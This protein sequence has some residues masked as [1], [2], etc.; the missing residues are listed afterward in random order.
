MAEIYIPKVLHILEIE[1][2]LAIG[3]VLVVSG[4]S[5][6][7]LPIVGSSCVRAVKGHT[8]RRHISDILARII[9]NCAILVAVD[10]CGMRVV[11]H[12]RSFAEINYYSTSGCHILARRHNH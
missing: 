11:H 2:N 8:R 10:D 4:I 12:G 5:A 6:G 3:N 9:A 7:A 1:L